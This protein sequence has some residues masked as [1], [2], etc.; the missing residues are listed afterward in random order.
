MNTQRTGGMTAIGI[1][2]IIFGVLRCL[3]GALIIL[4]GGLLAGLGA[5]SGEAAGQEVAVAGGLAAVLG[6]VA[7]ANG[8]LLLIGGIGVLKVA[9]WGRLFSLAAAALSVVITLGDGM[10]SGFGFGT[11]IGLIYPAVLF[12][13]FFQ[14]EWKA[15]FSGMPATAGT[16]TSEDE[17]RTAA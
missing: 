10:F 1:L 3:G 16:F 4:G 2:N 15:A 7:F 5:S 14:P 17:F 12:Y 8:V 6:L 13:V 9:S 11:L